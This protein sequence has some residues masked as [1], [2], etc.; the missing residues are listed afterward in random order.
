MTYDPDGGQEL[1]FSGR[2]GNEL[3]KDTWSWDGQSWRQ[4]AEDGP[5]KR[6]VYALVYDRA[7][8]QALFYGSGIRAEGRWI[9]DAETWIWRDRSWQLAE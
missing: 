5:L 7:E 1:L 8:H 9:L 4:L 3:L 6:G 2:Y